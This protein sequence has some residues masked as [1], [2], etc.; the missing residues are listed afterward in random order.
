MSV[1]KEVR[2]QLLEENN[3][4]KG[5]LFKLSQGFTLRLQLSN[6]IINATVRVFCNQPPNGNAFERNKYY[7]YNWIYLPNSIK[8][9][10]FNKFI[11]IECTKPGS[12]NYYFT[13]NNEEGQEKSKGG[14]NF[15]VTPNLVF[16]NGDFLDLNGV[17]IQTVLT[18]L[19][20]PLEEWKSRLVVAKE[21]NYNMIHF[22]PIQEL[23]PES[24]SSYC[25]SN[26]LKI[27]KTAD[28]NG[29]FALKDLD[30]II[31]FMYKEW[32]MFSICDLGN[33]FLYFF[34]FF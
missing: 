12:F 6:K 25:L 29:K 15:L 3:F 32:N 13:F 10:D 34:I 19:L 7:E 4:N 9:D 17:A 16:A 27:M 30:D 21:C 2:L 20:G 23:C 14:S 1:N 28:P 18:K 8:N 11:D 24:R 33:F 5:R 22:S 31:Q 26:H